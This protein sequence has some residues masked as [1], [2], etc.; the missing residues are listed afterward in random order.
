[1]VHPI[2]IFNIPTDFLTTMHAELDTDYL[3]DNPSGAD[4]DRWYWKMIAAYYYPPNNVPPYDE[5]F[6]FN[7]QNISSV[8][9]I[10]GVQGLIEGFFTYNSHHTLIYLNDHLVDDRIFPANAEYAFTCAEYPTIVS[11]GRHQHPDS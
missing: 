1:M 5:E 8:N 11:P 6:T 7:L 9:Q 2:I 4:R 3:S 10:I